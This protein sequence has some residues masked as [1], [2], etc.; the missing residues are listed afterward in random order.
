MSSLA[1]SQAAVRLN[2]S[3]SSRALD[4]DD[5]DDG[6]KSS[7]F[8]RIFSRRRR[9]RKATIAEDD[10]D[11][12]A[13]D[14]HR[15]KEERAKMRLVQQS[16]EAISQQHAACEQQE[17]VYANQ[18]ERFMEA[19]KRAKRENRPVDGKAALRQYHVATENYKKMGFMVQRILERRSELEQF[20]FSADF[21]S[22][23]RTFVET[24]KRLMARTHR[25][26]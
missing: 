8:A 11:P 26:R 22:L 18:A 14:D 3:L 12:F 17:R 21:I 23:S 20:K 19:A 7:C 24:T 9:L 1:R 4:D 10:V 5:D 13:L 16:L 15:T 25:C 6:G 2:T